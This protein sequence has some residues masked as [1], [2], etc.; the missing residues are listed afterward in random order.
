MLC[1]GR[2]K[3]L[4]LYGVIRWVSR[5][6]PCWQLALGPVDWKLSSFITHC[7]RI[8]LEMNLE[9]I[10]CHSEASSQTFQNIL[11]QQHIQVHQVQ[12]ACH[13]KKS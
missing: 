7:N 12:Q 10:G 5:N 1:E 3:G 11:Q 8:S 4:R 2:L 6:P 13:S 9:S